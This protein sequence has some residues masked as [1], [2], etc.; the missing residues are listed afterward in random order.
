MTNQNV[1]GL[2]YSQVG[3]DIGE[4]KR[5]IVRGHSINFLTEDAVLRLI[6]NKKNEILFET[7]FKYWGEI[8]GSHWWAADF[9]GFEKPGNYDVNVFDGGKV[10]FSGEGLQIGERIL[11][12]STWRL[13]AI[14]QLE[15][16]AVLAKAKIGWYDA[17][18]LWQEVNTHSSTI[19]G[20]C[21]LMSFSG[22]EM[23]ADDKSRI[24]K[25]ISN[26]CAYLAACQ[27]K[28]RELGYGEGP[29]SHDIIGHEEHILPADTSKAVV[30]WAKAAKITKD[31][32]Q[33]KE[34]LRRAELSMK[35][36]LFNAKPINSKYFSRLARGA[37]DE[38][39]I[40]DE[41]PT[42]ELIM[43]CWGAFELTKSGLDFYDTVAN[44]AKQIAG[45][46]VRES[47]KMDGLWGHFFSF[48]DR[49]ITEKAWTHNLEGGNFGCEVGATYPFFVLPLIELC[50]EWPDHPDAK[51]WKNTVANF[52]YGFFLPTCRR[53]PF[54]LLPLG[55]YGK[56][57][58]L[59]FAG[60]WHGMNAVYGLAA[61]MALEFEKFFQDKSFHEIA[62]GN[63]QWIAGLNSG[64]TRESM[65]PDFAVITSMD[66]PEGTALPVSMICG[67][68]KRWTG[69][70][71]NTRG[72]ICNG[73]STGKQFKFDV[74]PKKENDGPFAF[75]DEEWIVHPAGWLSGLSRL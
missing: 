64:V 36:L 58:L 12:N 44:F 59:W 67:V 26:G 3:Y 69:T 13:A 73:F 11:W 56:E 25:Q 53:N 74:D 40:P 48:S 34:Y 14:D 70:W 7:D 41:W 61:A 2:L 22:G 47:E 28:A 17:G 33:K 35:W 51:I 75:T 49:T 38:Y 23:N 68:G 19:I 42:N 62:V 10:I 5:A 54:F 31:K 60:L 16:R 43:F 57:G 66:I 20:L 18:G 27:D 6:S 4:P 8:W 72:V 29:L 37:S 65:A 39:N 30:A 50:R 32:D 63:L 46:Q 21:D 71:L 15:R 52:A 9:S 24:E 45:R 55:V 1:S